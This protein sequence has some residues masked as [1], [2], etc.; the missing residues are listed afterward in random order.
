MPTLPSA[1]NYY[2]D[3]Q[4]LTALAVRGARQASGL[5]AQAAQVA[6]YQALSATLA[7]QAAGEMLSAQGL[8][9]E[10]VAELNPAAF[11]TESRGTAAMIQAAATDE[12]VDRLVATLVAD[13]GRNAMGAA[14]IARPSANGHIRYLTSPSC[15]RCA[16]LAGRFYR[17]STGFQRHPRCDC[18]MVPSHSAIADGLTSDPML[19]FERGEIRGLSQADTEALRE[20]ADLSRVVNVRSR[21]AGL[22]PSGTSLTRGGRLTPDGIYRLADGNRDDAVRLLSEQGYLTAPHAK[23]SGTRIANANKATQS[24]LPLL[25]YTPGT[26]MPGLTVAEQDAITSYQLNGFHDVNE[27]LRGQRALAPVTE[28]LIEQLDGVLARSALDADMTLYR[29][30]QDRFDGLDV[31]AEFTDA[32]FVSTS[33]DEVTA[34]SMFAD[35]EVVRESGEFVE[36]VVIRLEVPRGTNALRLDSA[37]E[38]YAREKEVLLRRGARFRIT[39]EQRGI[40]GESPT[41][42][43][44]EMLP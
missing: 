40:P 34:V 1:A 12:A 23:Q 3:Q 42:L 31:G 8:D 39:R 16:V 30:I 41:I 6:A 36:S 26:D 10:P 19:A 43:W 27:A 44:A 22:S 24:D 9:P 2:R 11:T 20:G 14:T 7:D 25:T 17:W 5:A 35:A 13:S 18:Q 29:G 28:D 21:S 37:N 38:F 32:A 4:T 33:M 15:A